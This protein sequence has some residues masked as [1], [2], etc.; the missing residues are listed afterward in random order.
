MLIVFCMQVPI[1]VSPTDYEVL[2][3]HRPTEY[4][5]VPQWIAA[6]VKA[7]ADECKKTEMIL[8]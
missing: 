5:T 1:Y 4:T 7:K 8:A 6:I 2:G 3:K